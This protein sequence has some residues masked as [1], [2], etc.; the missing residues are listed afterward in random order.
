MHLQRCKMSTYGGAVNEIE[1]QGIKSCMCVCVC[2]RVRVIDKYV[3]L[4]FSSR[5]IRFLIRCLVLHIIMFENVLYLIGHLNDR[6]L[7]AKKGWLL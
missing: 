2:A 1:L 3:V 4:C 6:V 7:Y 5:V